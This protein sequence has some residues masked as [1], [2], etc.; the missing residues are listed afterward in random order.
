MFLFRGQKVNPWDGRPQ[1][2]DSDPSLTLRDFKKNAKPEKCSLAE[3]AL[4]KQLWLYLFDPLGAEA[5][6]LLSSRT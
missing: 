3:G 6:T 4:Q 1:G 2:G 5:T